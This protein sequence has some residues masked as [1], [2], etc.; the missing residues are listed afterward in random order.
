MSN[1]WIFWLEDLGKEHN[2]IVGRKCAHLGEMNKIGLNVPR[3]FALSI[4]AYN[5]FMI[6]SGAAEEIS[7]CLDASS[8]ITNDIGLLNILSKQI[9]SIIQSR[10]VPEEMR[11]KIVA[12]YRELCQ[13]Y[14]IAEVAVSTRSA[15]PVSHPGQ[16]E[17]FLNIKGEKAVVENI[18]KVW[19]STFNPRSLS[20]RLQKR[21]PLE[22]DPIGVAVIKMVEAKTAGVAF[23][24]DP[25]TGD[26][27]RITIE[28]NWGLGESVVNG[29]SMPDIYIVD[30]A[31]MEIEERK[32][33]RKSRCISCGSE[34]VIEAELPDEKACVFCL[35]DA[36]VKAIAE[37]SKRLEDYF[38]V[39]Q[40]VEWA[41]EENVPLPE[42]VYILQAR[43]EVI[44][45]TKAPVDQIIDL[46]LGHFSSGAFGDS[47]S[48]H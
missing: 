25:N 2:L 34:G 38:G 10:P 8:G 43:A 33:G 1:K 26:P 11:E 9:H 41:I 36:E 28:A 4:D 15:G 12:S 40:D 23:T 39:P 18:K 7:K 17:T 3:G 20:F 35:S 29:E 44:A 37:L 42:S 19:A 27:A 13:R 32:L 16:Y 30:K 47:D 5:E 31:S 46:M 6:T 22:S 14:N 45:Q 21:L 48:I 24:A